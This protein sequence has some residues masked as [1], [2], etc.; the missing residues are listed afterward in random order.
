MPDNQ[1]ESWELRDYKYENWCDL[2]ETWIVQDDFAEHQLEFCD[3]E[4]VID[5]SG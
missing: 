3:R 2:C 4:V 5:A 1:V